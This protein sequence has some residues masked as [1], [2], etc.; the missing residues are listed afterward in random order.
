MTVLEKWK[1]KAKALKQEIHAL[2][3]CC[4]DPRTP[5]YAKAFAGFIV[6]YALSPIDLIPDF[7]PV[8]GYLDELILLPVGIAAVRKMIPP[9][10]LDECR[11]KAKEASIQSRGKGWMVAGAIIAVWIIFA[12]LAAN[13]VGGYFWR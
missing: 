6:A 8:L 2:Y 11:L 9:V 4:K 12:V 10:V 13:W 1:E 5:W 3:L 7:I